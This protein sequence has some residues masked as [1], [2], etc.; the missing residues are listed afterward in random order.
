MVSVSQSST[1][2]VNQTAT[3]TDRDVSAMT[4]IMKTSSETATQKT[5][6]LLTA[7][8]VLMAIADASTVTR[9]FSQKFAENAIK[10]Q[11]GSMATVLWHVESMNS[12]TQAL[13]NASA[14]QAMVTSTLSVLFALETSS[15]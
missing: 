1:M 8:K 2:T 4:G 11:F 10:T 3:S 5:T 12:T 13:R 7:K 9:K 14:Y 15:L 6:V